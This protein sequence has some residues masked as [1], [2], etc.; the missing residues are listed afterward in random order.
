MQI[1]SYSLIIMVCTECN[2]EYEKSL[3]IGICDICG[4]Q[5]EINRD[6]TDILK[7]YLKNGTNDLIEKQECA[8]PICNVQNK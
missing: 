3:Y 7:K 2:K 8:D 6:F 1:E 5:E 4:T